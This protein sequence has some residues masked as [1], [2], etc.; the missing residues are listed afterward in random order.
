MRISVLGLRV[1]LFDPRIGNGVLISG[2]GIVGVGGE[3]V[4][5]SFFCLRG[6]VLGGRFGRRRVRR[7]FVWGLCWTFSECCGLCDGGSK[8]RNENLVYL[9]ERKMVGFGRLEGDVF[10]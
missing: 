8:S 1:R 4:D 7:V 2:F 5:A 9:G 6:G 10:G 3:V